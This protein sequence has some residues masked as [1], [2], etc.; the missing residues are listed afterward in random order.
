MIFR[1]TAV[2]QGISGEDLREKEGCFLVRNDSAELV[3]ST[4]TTDKPVGAVHIGA[5][6]G[7]S[8]TYLKPG[9]S[10]IVAV[11]L[12]SAPGTVKEGTDLVLMGDGR[13]KALPTAAGTYMVV[14]TAAETGEGDQLVKAATLERK[15]RIIWDVSDGTRCMTLRRS[16]IQVSMSDSPAMCS[17]IRRR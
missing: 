12:G 11:K 3:C 1:E 13:V 8:T 7:S 2:A 6:K 17:A 10:G 15:L 9:F 16:S 14:A 4:A 5:D